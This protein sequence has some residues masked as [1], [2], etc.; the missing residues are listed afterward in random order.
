MAGAQCA[1]VLDDAVQRVQQSHWRAAAGPS[2]T[3]T[4]RQTSQRQC[5]VTTI[6]KPTQL[7]REGFTNRS[8]FTER[9][10][11]SAV[12]A[13]VVCPSVCLSVTSQYCIETTGRIDL[14]LGMEASFHPSHTV[15]QGNLG[16]S[17]IWVFPSGTVPI[18][19]GLR[20]FCRGESIALSTTRRQ[21]SN[22]LTTPI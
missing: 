3:L 1:R 11:A 6:T 22:L 21:R 14:V 5:N 19:F 17:K 20:K 7:N 16:T 10:Y 15:L 9:R 2:Y 18:N 12:Y 13:V 8:I 4:R